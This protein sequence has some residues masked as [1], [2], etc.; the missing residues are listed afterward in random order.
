VASTLGCA[1]ASLIGSIIGVS[2]EYQT[3]FNT[4]EQAANFKSKM[5]NFLE[6][7]HRENGWGTVGP[8]M[9]IPN[10][11]IKGTIASQGD[12]IFIM[13]YPLKKDTAKLTITERD[14]KGKTSVGVC[15]YKE[16]GR[17]IELASC[18]FND[19]DYRK[20]KPHEVRTL[21]LEGVQNYVIVVRFNGM[22]MTN[23]LSY[24]LRLEV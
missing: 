22:S 14:G 8:R 5:V 20:D 13:P 1:V 15:K 21:R 6:R 24:T 16:G 19:T 2:V 18:I 17:H 11:D 23:T 10:T 9:L 4:A 7:Q 3:C 12:R